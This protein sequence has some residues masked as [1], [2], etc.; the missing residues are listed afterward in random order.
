M[1]ET[2]NL[3]RYSQVGALPSYNSSD[4]ESI[5]VKV[6]VKDE[7]QKIGNFFKQLDDTIALHQRE[8]DSLKEMKKS[9][10]QQMF[11]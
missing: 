3:P 9:L 6:P 11:V 5:D 8:L 4:I 1:F 7:Q 2:I 10:L